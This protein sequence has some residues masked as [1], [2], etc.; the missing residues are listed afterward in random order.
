MQFIAAKFIYCFDAELCHKQANWMC[1]AT[2]FFWEKGPLEV[3]LKPAN[4]PCKVSP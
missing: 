3:R 2:F 4:I 1:Q